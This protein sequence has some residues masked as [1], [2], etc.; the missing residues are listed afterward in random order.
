[1]TTITGPCDHTRTDPEML[2]VLN[3]ENRY[4]DAI[5][6]S[7]KPMAETLYG[8]I[9]GRI[10]QDDSSVP[11][12]K[13][14]Y[15]YYSRF[16]TGRDYAI[17]ARRKGSMQAPE[18][19]LFDQNAMAEG[20]GYFSIGDWQISPDNGKVAWAEDSIGRRQYRLLV[21]DLTTG[22][23][24]P[25]V[26][27]NIE[28]NIVWADDNKSLFY[29]EKDPVTLLSKRVKTHVLGK[30]V[31]SDA[32]VYEESDDSFYMGLSRTRSENFI[33]ITIESTVSSE[34]R[35]APAANPAQFAVIAGRERNF[36][37]SSRSLGWPLADTHQLERTELPVD[38]P[39]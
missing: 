1:M 7:S 20:K 2:V 32:L 21:K 29:I 9:T 13:H 6:A 15:W 3:A 39:G 25:D 14:G 33:C 30:P 28:P 8:E 22:E 38:D 16:E 24:F 37:Y 19:I 17:I 36:E 10:K 27:D 18:E 23:I 26:V 31:E 12:L 4:A 5:L 11:Y 35:V 34:Q